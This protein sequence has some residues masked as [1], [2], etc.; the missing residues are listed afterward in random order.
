M[1]EE[2]ELLLVLLL[3]HQDSM[4]KN[5]DLNCGINNGC[6]DKLKNVPESCNLA[7]FNALKKA[8]NG[9]ALYKA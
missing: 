9:D 1:S 3:L 4:I 8:K 6:I 7:L 2:I 5:P